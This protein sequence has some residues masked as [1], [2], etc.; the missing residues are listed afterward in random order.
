MPSRLRRRARKRKT[1]PSFVNK[2]STIKGRRDR[3]MMVL[4]PDAVAGIAAQ[5]IRLFKRF[6]RCPE[7]LGLGD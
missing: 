7:I 1:A 5:R 3:V 2:Q 4:V 6:E